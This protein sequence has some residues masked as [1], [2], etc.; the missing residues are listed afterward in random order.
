[1]LL[2]IIFESISVLGCFIDRIT[3]AL[4]SYALVVPDQ[5]LSCLASST[6]GLCS[7]DQYYEDWETV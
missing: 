5:P 6:A 3:R 2:F 1:M 7:F 4:R